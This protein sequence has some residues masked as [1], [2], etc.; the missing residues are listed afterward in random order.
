MDLN[1][2]YFQ[3]KIEHLSLK[4]IKERWKIIINFVNLVLYHRIRNLT[5]LTN[6]EK[7]CRSLLVL[8]FATPES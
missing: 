6:D 3:L 7:C 8:I 4:N 5:E 2:S 1:N